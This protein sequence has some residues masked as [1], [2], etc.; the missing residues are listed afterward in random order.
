MK[1]SDLEK[2]VS[3]APLAENTGFGKVAQT[4]VQKTITRALETAFYCAQT[5]GR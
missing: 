5:S 2:S 4:I 3:D 1:N